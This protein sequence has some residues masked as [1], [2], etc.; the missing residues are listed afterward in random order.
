M[1]RYRFTLQAEQDLADLTNFI[2]GN[3]PAAGV[4][5]L[6]LIE[7][8]CA[9]LARYP[10]AGRTR[11]ELLPGIRSFPASSYVIFYR[12]AGDEVQILRVLHG[13]RDVES[14]FAS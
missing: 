6:D 5:M 4:A 3:N 14:E 7:E 2:A 13:S 12:V 9:M 10:E 1:S 11:E 8:R